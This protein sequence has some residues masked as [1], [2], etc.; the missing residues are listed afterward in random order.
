MGP[1]P[2]PGGLPTPEIQV[3]A[4]ETSPPNPIIPTP[5]ETHEPVPPAAE[6]ENS[7]FFSLRGNLL[8]HRQIL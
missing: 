2:L 6:V 3:G 1:L 7:I 4:Q 8:T 5:P